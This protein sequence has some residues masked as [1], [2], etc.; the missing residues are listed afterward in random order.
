M[1]RSGLR[2][3]CVPT[4]PHISARRQ[5]TAVGWLVLIALAA[6]CSTPQCLVAQPSA[7]QQDEEETVQLNFPNEIDIKTLVDYVSERLKI[8]VFYDEKIEQQRI[9]VRAPEPIP[10]S[11]LLGILQSTLRMKGFA[12][13]EADTPGWYR[14][15]QVTRLTDVA[16]LGLEG[17]EHGAIP[18]T[19]TFQL[20]H[21]EVATMDQII[22]QFLT[23]PGANSIPVPEGNLLIVTDYAGNLAR[24]GQ[25]IRTLDQPEAKLLTDFYEVKH[26]SAEAITQ[27]I[28]PILAA[29]APAGGAGVQLLPDPRTNQITLVGIEPEVARAMEL[30]ERFDIPLGLT[31]FVYQFGN[32]AAERVDTLFQELIDPIERETV[33]QSTVDADANLLIVRTKPELH[34]RLNQL[35][36]QIDAAP[37]QARSPVRFLKL[38]NANVDD[39]LQTLRA[40]GDLGA[41]PAGVPLEGEG[42]AA[43]PFQSPQSGGSQFLNPSSAPLPFQPFVMPLGP[44]DPYDLRDNPP[45]AGEPVRTSVAGAYLP[46]DVRVS[47]DPITN[48]LVLVGDPAQQAPYLKLIEQLDA[49]RPQVMIEAHIVAIDTSDN[50]SLGVEVSGGDR[51][52]IKRLFSFSSFGLSEVDP[53]TGALQII[54]NLGFNGTLVDPEVADVV[55]QALAAH[56]R[57]RVLA[58]PKILV[59]DNTRG[60]FE[61]VLSV[62]FQSVNASQTVSTTSLG[63]SQQAGTTIDVTPH[64]KDGNE[65]ELEFDV[66]FSAF[67]GTSAAAALPPPRQISRAE[68]IVTIP[69][70]HT[71]I[72]GGLKQIG[73]TETFAG[74]PFLE[75]VPILRELSSLQTKDRT[76]TSFFLF[77]KPVILRNDQFA[78]LKYLSAKDHQQSELQARF[79]ASGPL[80]IRCNRKAHGH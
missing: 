41:G 78:T 54:P 12:L 50:F 58:S 25:L 15:V 57:S 45:G 29:R 32:V 27:T 76:Q 68:S 44:Y 66:E 51:M 4:A 9:T 39:V 34:E 5:G 70:G 26:I 7:G 65:L 77:L 6:L 55:V 2:Q 64:V 23:Q 1:F 21:T 33:Y 10:V 31:T 71:V 35:R 37:E 53:V 61:N 38:K 42:A 48:S 47:G 49:P 62:P 8:S 56:S 43:A 24:I 69:D 17:V 63:G 40:I 72:V 67:S 60:S 13:V 11:S 73:V 80:M 28:T 16:R 46:G 36:Q 79:P 30:L 52:G 74:I 14:V 3:P 75:L 59:N 19:E 22:Q 20:K 18:V